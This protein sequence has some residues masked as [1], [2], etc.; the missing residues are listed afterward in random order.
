LIT[1]FKIFSNNNAT[2]KNE[3][4]NCKFNDF[5]IENGYTVKDVQS[6]MGFEKSPGDPY[7]NRKNQIDFMQT[8]D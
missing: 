3:F 2:T 1:R 4:L 8:L 6:A 7:K 5:S